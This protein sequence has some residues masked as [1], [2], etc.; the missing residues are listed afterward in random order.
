MS[1]TG[2]GASVNQLP[3]NSTWNQAALLAKRD[4]PASDYS[5]HV[6]WEKTGVLG[7]YGGTLGSFLEESSGQH[8]KKGVRT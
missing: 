4:F 5:M 2:L 7:V 8:S 1:G 6:C 3:G